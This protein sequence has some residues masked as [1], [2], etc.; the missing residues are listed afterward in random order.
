LIGF[1]AS[2]VKQESMLIFSKLGIS[3]RKEINPK[4]NLAKTPIKN[5]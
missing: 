1:S 2:L 5:S 3:G 4:N